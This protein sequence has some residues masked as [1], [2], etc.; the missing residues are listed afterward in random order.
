MLLVGQQEGIL[1][2]Q[3]LSGLPVGDLACTPLK[4][5]SVSTLTMEPFVTS[6]HC[7]HGRSTGGST[8]DGC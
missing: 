6:M 5:E 2:K 1:S 3:K 4:T 8:V 7:I